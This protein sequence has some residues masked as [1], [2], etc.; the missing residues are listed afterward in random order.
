[1]QNPSSDCIMN[2]I[3][4]F[5][6]VISSGLLPRGFQI[7]ILYE[8]LISSSGIISPMPPCLLSITHTIAEMIGTFSPDSPFPQKARN[9]SD[10]R[11]IPVFQVGHHFELPQLYYLCAYA[12]NH[13]T[14]N[15][16]RPPSYWSTACGISTSSESRR[17]GLVFFF[18]PPSY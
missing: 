12:S 8:F 15:T 18:C 9:S 16:T 1:L 13:M 4:L 5:Y 2:Q 11:G 6:L 17:V 7:K 14:V 3:T 10:Y